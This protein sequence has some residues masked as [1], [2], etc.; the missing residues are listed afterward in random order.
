MLEKLVGKQVKAGHCESVWLEFEHSFLNRDN[1]KFILG[2]IYRSPSSPV[3]QF[4][5]NLQHSL[6]AISLENKNAI[7]MGDIN[8]NLLDDLSPNTINYLS[9]LNSYG[10]ECLINI[11]TR[12][13][14]NSSGSLIDHALSNLLNPP[15][16]VV[17]EID[18]TD[19]YPIVMCFNH[20]VK[21]HSTSFTRCILNKEKFVDAVGNI[22]W[23]EVYLMNNAQEAF[24]LFS[25]LLLTHV[26]S[27]TDKHKCKKVIASEKNPWLTDRLLTEMRK[28]DNLYRKTKR[29]RFNTKLLARYKKFCNQLNSQLKGAKRNYYE[30]KLTDAGNSTRK[31]WEI[32]N[33][34]LNRSTHPNSITE[35]IYNNVTY[36]DPTDIA[37]HFA[38]FFFQAE[39]SPPPLNAVD[40]DRLPHSFFLFPSTP[41]EI[42]NIIRNLKVTSAGLDGLHS[43]HIK[44]VGHLISNVL[45]FIVNLIFKSGVFPQELK[46]GKIIPVHKKGET[47]QLNNYR[48]I[49]ILPF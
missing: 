23:S 14:C 10:Y 43:T 13:N 22:D 38:N 45:A 41:D 16:A 25:Y 18:I 27:C 30:H 3:S 48:P 40:L 32:I 7:I 35:V 34:F 15:V 17:L 20:D 9:T 28:R 12:P 29:Q 11:P 26:Q 37:N 42:L 5:A 44:M 1:K 24:T 36:S 21:P 8:I 46:Q 2:C 19:H 6:N 47:S 39:S 33:S 4:C 31:K 49:C